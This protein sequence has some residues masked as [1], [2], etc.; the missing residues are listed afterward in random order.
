METLS[1]APAR[2]SLRDRILNIIDN[3]EA[4][5]QLKEAEEAAKKRRW[6]RHKADMLRRRGARMI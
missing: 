6:G 3:M 2:V 1:P 4:Q 5:E